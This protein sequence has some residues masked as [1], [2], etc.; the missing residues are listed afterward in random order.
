MRFFET[1]FDDYISTSQKMNFHPKIDKIIK[2]LPNLHNLY[3]IILFGPCGVGKYTQM[4]N[5]VKNYS[6]S[7]L[8]YEKK[9]SIT[10]N[11]QQYF[12]KIS[13]IHYEIDMSLLGCNSKLLWHEIYVQII[14]II[15]TSKQ[16]ANIGI[17]VCKNFQEIHNELLDNFYSY[18][19]KKNNTLSSTSTNVALK[20]ILIT[21]EISF[22]P[23]N[24]LNCCKTI[25]VARPSKTQYNKGL[26]E[27]GYSTSVINQMSSSS[28][29]SNIKNLY[30]Q[31][32][33]HL[34]LP[35]KFVCDKILNAII[36]LHDLNF[37]K[38][39]DLLY[40]IFIYNLD[41]SKCIWYIV[42]QLIEQEELMP[43]DIS[44]TLIKI[45]SFFYYYNNNYRPIFH[46]ENLLL[47]LAAKCASK[48]NG[49]G[50]VSVIQLKIE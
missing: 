6:K 44:E 45:Y 47:F 25:S 33:N 2:T 1:H 28:Q 13:D 11:K 40:D 7:E 41:V 10:Y 37:L 20:F 21:E 39:R 24:I 49:I 17:V 8:K 35:H 26:I 15:Y 12:L 9:I 19:Q 43:T 14:D 42:I 31:D 34:T 46:I 22:I 16:K 4:L 18:M 29:I 5:I 38:F 48:S 27:N 3:N 50:L 36:D 30:C 23:N 32:I